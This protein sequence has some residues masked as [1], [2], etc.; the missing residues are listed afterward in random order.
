MRDSDCQQ[1]VGDRDAA[2]ICAIERLVPIDLLLVNDIAGVYQARCRNVPA[3]PH[4]NQ[5]RVSSPHRPSRV[6]ASGQ[7]AIA[8]A[9]VRCWLEAVTSRTPFTARTRAPLSRANRQL[10][11]SLRDCIVKT[12]CTR[13]AHD[14]LESR[15]SAGQSYRSTMGATQRRCEWE[16]MRPIR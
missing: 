10:R 15:A 1:E 14:R 9:L 16:V 12:N 7:S 5:F 3:H 4:W 11:P 8:I 13:N 2:M 6:S